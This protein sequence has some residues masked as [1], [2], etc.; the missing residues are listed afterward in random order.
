MTT[1]EVSQDIVDVAQAL[2]RRVYTLE[3]RITSPSY[4][5]P[6]GSSPTF[7]EIIVG[8]WSPDTG[9][10]NGVPIQSTV[11]SPT[12][13]TLTSTAT[14]EDVSIDAS[15]MAP[16]DGTAASYEVTVAARQADGTYLPVNIV[17]V[18]GTNAHVG[19]LLPGRVYGVTV[20]SINRI[21]VVSAPY[22]AVGMQ[23][24]TTA[25]DATIPSGITGLKVDAAYSSVTL[26]WSESSESDVGGGAGQYQVQQ[27]DDEAFTVNVLSNRTSATIV[28]FTGLVT[29]KRYYYRVRAVDSSGNE[30]PWTTPV[31]AEPGGGTGASSDGLAP[32][33]SPQPSVSGGPGFLFVRWSKVSNADQTTYE[34]H[35]S[36]AAG[37]APGPGTKVAE[38]DGSIAVIK[39]DG[40]NV[41]L[42]YDTDYYLLTVAKDADGVAPSS[43][44]T[45]PVRL[46]R[47]GT[48]DIAAGSITAASGIIADLDAGVIKVGTL[49]ADRIAADSIRITQLNVASRTQGQNMMPNGSLADWPGSGDA[50]GW[51]RAH[52]TAGYYLERSNNHWQ[53]PGP[54]ALVHAGGGDG[55]V[56]Y[57]IGTDIPVTAN[58]I[59]YGEVTAGHSSADAAIFMR[60]H[61][62]NAD[63]TYLGERDFFGGAM[64]GGNVSRVYSGRVQV[65]ASATYVRVQVIT[66]GGAHIV[67]SGAVM[68]KAVGG[69][70]IRDGAITAPKI[71]AGQINSD[72]VVTAG[73][74]AGVIKFGFMHGDRI[75]ANTMDV[76]ALRSSTLTSRTL[77][78][79][80]NGQIIVGNSTTGIYIDQFGIRLFG[81]GSTKVHLDA[82][83]GNATVTGTINA[84]AGNFTGS[85]TSSATIT[86]GTFQTAS[87]GHRIRLNGNRL[88]FLNSAGGMSTPAH[89]EVRDSVFGASFGQTTTISGGNPSY[90][91]GKY[92]YIDLSPGGSGNTLVIST[93]ASDTGAADSN[94]Y[95]Y[96]R[97]RVEIDAQDRLLLS[98]SSVSTLGTEFVL[99]GAN[100]IEYLVGGFFHTFMD[101]G[102]TPCNVQAAKFIVIS[103]EDSKTK[104]TKM[105][106]GAL[107]AVVRMDK[108]KFKRKSDKRANT[109]ALGFRAEDVAAIAPEA[110][111]YLEDGTLTGV[112][113]DSMIALAFKA[114]EELSVVVNGK[115]DKAVRTSK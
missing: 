38:I 92:S 51:Y 23:E 12:N 6:N 37:F 31:W 24:V 48:S 78:I 14:F 36:T 70:M 16:A 71:V 79:G 25:K 26:Q 73:L 89:I 1:I 18:V 102:R 17:T 50:R 43:A 108:V 74:D 22:P 95:L 45:G 35:L 9:T 93:G 85:I 87:S 104:P 115:A 42:K 41:S 63:R 15:W 68:N 32:A 106:G 52:G 90:R 76:G 61:F 96:S 7:S 39:N 64:S 58:D 65:P 33:S 86:G 49:N 97:G 107:D 94:M 53:T 77:T 100:D 98:R 30:G 83:N 105:T 55:H 40:N 5:V 99:N 3:Q 21:G 29:G 88:T 4:V 10:N 80:S 81:G 101:I 84:T 28:S 72:H 111:A 2:L 20:K 19:G 67:W 59:L 46:V 54:N 56:W 62:F 11:G 57:E 109:E 69:V 110:A 47:S 27:A 13:L 112:A 8:D 113:M 66:R 34:V 60:C 103:T 114:I 75:S 91:P 82:G 44:V